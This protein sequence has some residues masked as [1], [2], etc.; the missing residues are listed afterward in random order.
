MGIF[1][2]V[3]G[4]D[5]RYSKYRKTADLALQELIVHS[6]NTGKDFEKIMSLKDNMEP[7]I[8]ICAYLV[9]YIAVT[10]ESTG[11][12]HV[13]VYKKYTIARA[14]KDAVDAI[15]YKGIDMDIVYTR[16]LPELT[17]EDKSGTMVD[18][19]AHQTTFSVPGSVVAQFMMIGNKKDALFN[20][21]ICLDTMMMESPAYDANGHSNHKDYQF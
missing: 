10:F 17:K 13:K 19:I 1:S 7:D 2:T 21:T 20:M 16:M 12:H 9:G 14:A 4:T 6:H 3:S 11:Y 8:R 18:Y 5:A 15:G